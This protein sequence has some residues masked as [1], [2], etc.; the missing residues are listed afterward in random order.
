MVGSAWPCA[1][2]AKF[3]FVG[4]GGDV[5]SAVSSTRAHVSWQGW[6]V[7][8]PN[9]KR[10]RRLHVMGTN[11]AGRFFLGTKAKNFHNCSYKW[12]KR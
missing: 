6:R 2:N 4:A 1:L 3:P 10:P 8:K 7:I 9:S 5:H 11:L 12:S